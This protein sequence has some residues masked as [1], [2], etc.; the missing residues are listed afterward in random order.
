MVRRLVEQQEL[1]VLRQNLREERA[2]QLA[3]G[4]RQNRLPPLVLQAG[5]RQ[6]LLDVPGVVLLAAAEHAS[7]I[8]EAP[9]AHDL[10]DC[11]AVADKVVLRQNADGPR[12][13][14]GLH[15]PYIL[16][17]KQHAARI[18]RPLRDGG[19]RCRFACPVRACDHEPLPLGNG[20]GERV[21]DLLCPVPHRKTVDIQ[22]RHISA[23]FSTDR[24]SPR[25]RSRPQSS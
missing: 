6:R 11:E 10:L 22:H 12:A 18:R 24:R 19:K 23:P 25:I 3:A 21:D 5:E 8:G 14:R 7:C 13:K 4:E 20:K 15:A 1:R 9:K 16:S 2:L 17:F